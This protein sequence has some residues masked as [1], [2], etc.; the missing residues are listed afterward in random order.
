MEVLLSKSVNY[1]CI[2]EQT[3]F[4]LLN[5]INPSLGGLGL[6]AV[7]FCPGHIRGPSVSYGGREEEAV[8]AN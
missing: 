1:E 6:F 4:H 7:L 5:V 3:R 8:D 2:T